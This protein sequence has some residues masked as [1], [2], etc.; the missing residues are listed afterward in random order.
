[1]QGWSQTPSM[2]AAPVY[3]VREVIRFDMTPMGLLQRFQQV[4]TIPGNPHYDIQRVALSTGTQPTDLAGTLTYFFDAN[5]VVQR[6]QFTG[7]TGDPSMIASMMVQYY[8]L[9][10]EPS[11]GGQLFTTRWNGRVTSLMH[12]TP[13]AV[14]QYS[15]NAHA[16]YSVFMELNQ[17]S[18]YYGLS[19]EAARFLPP[20]AQR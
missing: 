3:D 18:P 13:A 12:A 16:N 9:Q 1:M 14:L 10:P 17:P 2:V 6:I 19:E 11:L 4:T 5:K 15:P 20:Q 7:T 8:R